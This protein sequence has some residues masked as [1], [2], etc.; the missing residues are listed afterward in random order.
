MK[1]FVRN[2]NDKLR[3]RGRYGVDAF[4]RMLLIAAV[5][6]LTLGLLLDLWIFSLYAIFPAVWS[7]VRIFSK[8][9][10]KRETELEAYEDMAKRRQENAALRKRRWADRKTFR[11]FRCK[12]CDTVF[13]VPR[14]KGKVN[15]TCPVCGEK[16]IKRT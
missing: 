15:V 10:D 14:G 5:I 11:Y 13:R 6:V 8:N 3:K 9:I 1:D 4:S 2:I 7:C 16:F 12:Y